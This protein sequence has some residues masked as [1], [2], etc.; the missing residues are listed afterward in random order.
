M[1]KMVVFGGAF[2]PPLNSHFMFAEA[3]VNEFNDVKKVIF[4]P[5]NSEYQKKETVIENEHRY[6]MLKLVCGKNE[7]FDVSRMEIDSPRPL[8]TIETLERMQNLYPQ[9]Q[10]IFATGTDNLKEFETWHEP[11]KIV[12]N[13]K[14]IVF[15][16]N[17]DN[18]E[19]IIEGSEFLSKN[20]DAFIKL[21]TELKTDLSSTYARK[22]LRK[23]KSIRYIAPEEVYNYI[24]ENK[25]YL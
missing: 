24:I 15:E 9:M 7:K 5:V 3:L 2:N 23:G 25:L 22:M 18:M 17:R 10:I 19:Q 13:F 4:M 16:R 14:I 8:Y 21:N 1:E 12:D 20:K 11:Q 6:N